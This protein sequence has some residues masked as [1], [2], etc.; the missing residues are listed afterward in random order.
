MKMTIMK[1]A[2]EGDVPFKSEVIARNVPIEWAQLLVQ[3]L[4]NG[5]DTP[6]GDRFAMIPERE[7]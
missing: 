3:F 7:D 6:T 2:K 1:L 4:E 5:Y